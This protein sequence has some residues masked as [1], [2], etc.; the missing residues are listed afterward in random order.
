MLL[1]VSDDS[2]IRFCAAFRSALHTLMTYL[3]PVT[4]QPSTWIIFGKFSPACKS[5][6]CRYTPTSVS[7]VLPHSTYFHSM[8]IS[9]AFAPWMIKCRSSR[10]FHSHPHSVSL[11]QFLGLVNFYP[12]FLPHCV[13]VLQPL[14]DL[15][16]T[17]PK[18][19]TSLEWTDSALTAF[20]DIKEALASASLLVHPQLGAPTCILTD[21]SNEMFFSR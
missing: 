15:L 20:K 16:K 8:L 6:A 12:H 11:R 17:A 13:Q 4:M 19:N 9:T 5:M 2:S 7:W 18:G 10:I 1:Q 14:H 3:W 21:A